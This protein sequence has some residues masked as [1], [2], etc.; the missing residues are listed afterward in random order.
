MGENKETLKVEGLGVNTVPAVEGMNNKIDV[1]STPTVASK[2]EA[3]KLDVTA[4]PTVSQAPAAKIDPSAIPTSS[5]A[6]QSSDKDITKIIFIVIGA[7]I[8]LSVL[9]IIITSVTGKKLVC[10]YNYDYMGE[11]RETTITVK[12]N[13]DDKVKYIKEESKRDLTNSN[14][15]ND[16]SD[17]ELDNMLKNEVKDLKGD[18]IKY[19]RDGKVLSYS[20]EYNSDKL[21]SYS[22]FKYEDMKKSLESSSFSCK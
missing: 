13:G 20:Y 6:G 12:F 16:K 11:K 4:S 9:I 1:T 18:K 3:Q 5:T 21:K 10:T 14:M 17:E 7:F 8:A 2:P 22:S 15:H 19:K